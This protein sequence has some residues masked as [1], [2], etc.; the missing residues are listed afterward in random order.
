MSINQGE[1]TLEAE[2]YLIRDARIYADLEGRQESQEE[3]TERLD[4][5]VELFASDLSDLQIIDLVESETQHA[6]HYEKDEKEIPA[7]IEKNT[8]MLHTAIFVLPRIDTIRAIRLYKEALETPDYPETAAMVV[9]GLLNLSSI[10]L[11]RGTIGLWK[12]AF[13][14]PGTKASDWAR[15]YLADPR[16]E[17]NGL[18]GDQE[19]EKLSRLGNKLI[20][21]RRQR[22]SDLLERADQSINPDQG[23]S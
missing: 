2:A 16:G 6:K 14:Y 8:D 1:A 19:I 9:N 22:D 23:E 10:D 20:G 7:T 11:G 18:L 17:A 5:I 13:N 4:R 12:K 15:Q 3:T 21:M